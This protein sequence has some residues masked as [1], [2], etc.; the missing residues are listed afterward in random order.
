MA[1]ALCWQSLKL[2][3]VKLASGADWLL[4]DGS[5]TSVPFADGITLPTTAAN[6]LSAVFIGSVGPSAP[7][8][9]PPAVVATADPRRQ[10]TAQ[11]A[12][13]GGAGGGCGG[14]GGGNMQQIQALQVEPLSPC[15][16]VRVGQLGL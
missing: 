7:R 16:R 11:E 4:R 1:R 15:A 5:G 10:S 3:L 8:T 12:T 6:P 9:Q 14:A 13:G 2:E